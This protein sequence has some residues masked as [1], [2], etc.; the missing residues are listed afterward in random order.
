MS[1]LRAIV[2]LRY[3]LVANRIRR[4]GTANRVV[5]MIALVLGV[6]TSLTMFAIAMVVGC[7]GT[8]DV[9]T[10]VLLLIWNGLAIAFLFGWSIGV[11]T[12][13]SQSE[14]VPLSSFLHLPVS[15][16]G[17]FVMNYLGSLIS[18][19]MIL[20]LPVIVGIALSHVAL[21]GPRM[22][23]GLLLV[24]GF[25]LM[26]TSVTYQFRG[27]LASRMMN[28]RQQKTV[29]AV[30]TLGFVLMTQIPNLL[31]SFVFKKFTEQDR[32]EER[33][34]AEEVDQWN[35]QVET[36]E[37]PQDELD[38]RVEKYVAETAEKKKQKFAVLMG[39]VRLADAAIPPGW[40]PLGIERLASKRWFS[41]FGCLAGLLGLSLIS[42]SRSYKTTLRLYRGE[43][44]SFW[45]KKKTVSE[46]SA[47]AER[48]A[49]EKSLH[50]IAGKFPLLSERQ[51][52]IAGA[53]LLGF[54][55]APEVKLAA[56]TPL[57]IMII[58]L[59]GLVFNLNDTDVAQPHL[60]A[61]MA[62]GT[63][64]FSMIG[65]IQLTQCQF[66]YDRD[67]FRVYML[68][69]VVG[70]DILIGKNAALAPLA[71]GLSLFGLIV[72]QVIFPLDW[73]H[74]IA[75]F[76]S[77]A[78]I[79]LIA[80]MNGNLI[81]ILAP[82]AVKSGTLQPSNASLIVMLVQFIAIISLPIVMFP[83]LLPIFVDWI[84]TAFL[85][86][87]GP[88]YLLLSLVV[89]AMTLGAYHLAVSHQGQLLENRQKQILEIV[90]R[91]S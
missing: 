83:V 6:I 5:A 73:T 16:W 39:Y 28:N 7:I 11:L 51:S 9:S 24:A 18:I 62:I 35:R 4:M 57:I 80:C 86:W 56:V 32:V 60:R 67:G 50:W 30:V 21:L 42:L 75:S 81:S 1:Q 13:L 3:R 65:L 71:L 70:K 85:G 15:P 82:Y 58:V 64:L 69:P 89:F 76:F 48:I 54:R 53:A 91:A 41:S 47:R 26:V 8:F 14:P 55:R 22:L 33:E 38:R 45:T 79:F 46:K 40:M 66:G 29:I 19:T 74:F 34:H 90:T 63:C 52:A 23:M 43:V 61:L 25:V 77:I 20:L 84:L 12:E 78:S 68:S 31:N 87:H 88:W 37:L 36:G 44:N 2:W 10:D 72:F 49:S 59:V 27:W 17:V